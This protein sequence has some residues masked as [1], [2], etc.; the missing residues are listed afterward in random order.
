MSNV[1][2]T[3]HLRVYEPASAFGEHLQLRL[4]WAAA[5]THSR[6]DELTRQRS[7]A[8]VAR[9]VPDPFPPTDQKDLSRVLYASDG[10]RVFC[11]DQLSLRA[12]V[13]ADELR[14]LLTPEAFDALI[15]PAALQRHRTR[16]TEDLR[17]ATDP[18]AGEDTPRPG[19]RL[20][21][22]SSTWSVPLSWLLMLD[23]DEEPYRRDDD[24]TARRTEVLPAALARLWKAEGVLKV[25]A[26]DADLLP[27]VTDLIAWLQ[28]FGQDAVLELDYGTLT[29]WVWPDESAFD[30]WTLL[31]AL[32]VQDEATASVAQDRLNKR[33]STVALRAQA[34]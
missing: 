28:G 32:E 29:D 18:R 15:P 21:T 1:V 14:E 25:H 24:V 34:N 10:S 33:W 27:E 2:G 20:R 22:R 7:L 26:A 19:E 5:L 9:R 11:P 31:D 12:A 16:V 3:A 13:A 30:L 23:P 17:E 6:V 8:R 4:S